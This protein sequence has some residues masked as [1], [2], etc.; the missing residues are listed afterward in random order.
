MWEMLPP[1]TNQSFPPDVTAAAADWA[2]CWPS[3]SGLTAATFATC[4]A[5]QKAIIAGHLADFKK[6]VAP[7]IDALWSAHSAW[8]S[9][10]PTM[11]CQSG[12]DPTVTIGGVSVG[13]GAADWYFNR[14][15]RRIVDVD[16]PNP[17]CPGSC[18]K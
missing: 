11:H 6:A 16:F 17:T 14:S 1:P 8:L 9:A 4:N 13:D 10:C 3:I 5:T 2:E 15:P 7:I 18:P 12:F